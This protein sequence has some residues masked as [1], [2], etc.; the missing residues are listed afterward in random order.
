[1]TISVKDLGQ[2]MHFNGVDILQ[3]RQYIK[4]YNETYI[5]K[6]TTKYQWINKAKEQEIFPIPIHHDI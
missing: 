4:L 3:T 2:L 5:N 1:M 6:I